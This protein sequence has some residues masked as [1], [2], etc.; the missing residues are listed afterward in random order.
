MTDTTTIT[1]TLNV[2]QIN[3]ILQALGAGPFAQVEPL[4]TEIRNQAI[5]QVPQ[6]APEEEAVTQ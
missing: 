1:L 5:P 6:E 4:I 3:L 2:A